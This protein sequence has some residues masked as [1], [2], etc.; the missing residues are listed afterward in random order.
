MR[1]GYVLHPLDV[2]NIIDAPLSVDVMPGNM[3]LLLKNSHQKFSSE[4]VVSPNKIRLIQ[5]K[6]KP[7][8]MLPLTLMAD[9]RSRLG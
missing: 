2:A 1:S 7:N 6:E 8:N 9:L 3:D 5:V 4:V